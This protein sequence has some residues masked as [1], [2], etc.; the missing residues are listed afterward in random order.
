M[1]LF[2]SLVNCSL[3][4]LNDQVPELRDVGVKVRPSAEPLRP[5]HGLSWV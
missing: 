3:A 2:N 1:G 5:G 4:I